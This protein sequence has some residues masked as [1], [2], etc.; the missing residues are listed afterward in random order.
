MQCPVCLGSRIGGCL[1][2]REEAA[3]LSGQ[4]DAGLEP[5]EVRSGLERR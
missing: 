1:G 4:S 5:G 3:E 2:T